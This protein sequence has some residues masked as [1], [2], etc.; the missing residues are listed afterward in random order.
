MYYD[1]SDNIFIR[2]MRSITDKIAEGLSMWSYKTQLTT[3]MEVIQ[4]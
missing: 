4:E 1:E 3:S 2:S